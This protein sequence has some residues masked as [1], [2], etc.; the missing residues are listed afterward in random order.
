MYDSGPSVNTLLS[1]AVSQPRY[2]L[3]LFC[4][5]LVTLQK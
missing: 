5:E 2:R 4:T 1:I 3:S